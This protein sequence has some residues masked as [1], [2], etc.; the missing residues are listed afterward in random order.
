MIVIW[1]PDIKNSFLVIAHDSAIC[2]NVLWRDKSSQ[3]QTQ[4]ANREN[5]SIG[6]VE[7]I[8]PGSVT[9]STTSVEVFKLLRS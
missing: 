4:I 2:V 5:D 6:Q 7:L 8:L 3:P 1:H 9:L